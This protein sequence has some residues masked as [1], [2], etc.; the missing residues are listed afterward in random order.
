MNRSEPQS[1]GTGRSADYPVESMLA[2]L[3]SITD[4]LRHG[5]PDPTKPARRWSLTA[6]TLF[7]AARIRSRDKLPRVESG[8]GGNGHGDPTYGDAAALVV[9]ND[10]DR[11][12]WLELRTDVEVM[13][14][15]GRHAVGVLDKATPAQQRPDKIE[16]CCRVCGDKTLYRS[17]RCRWCYDRWCEYGVDMPERIV[18]W[19]K[20]GKA[21]PPSLIRAE[22]GEEL[23]G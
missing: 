5:I 1:F 19:H 14:T 22:L 13:L 6:F 17:E 21:T 4:R 20:A 2:E 11:K 18:R 9:D 15:H 3:E 16:P 8:R 7:A 10:P 12:A 23:A